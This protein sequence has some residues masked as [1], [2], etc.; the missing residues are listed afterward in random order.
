[1]RSKI[2]FFVNIAILVLVGI[3]LGK[4]WQRGREVN[5]EISGLQNRL[6]TA[7]Q[8]NV[9]LNELI[10][11]LNSQAFIEEKARRDLGLK[12]EGERVVV[13]TDEVIGNNLLQSSRTEAESSRPATNAAKWMDF[14]FK[15]H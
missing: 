2:F 1:M 15:I 6:V 4:V 3:G 8:K 10:T 11:Y 12:G 5:Q 9:E 13:I 7:Q 14:F